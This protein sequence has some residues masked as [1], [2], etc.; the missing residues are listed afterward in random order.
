MNENLKWGVTV[1]VVVASSIGGLSYG[2][3]L[4]AIHQAK[5]KVS[6]QLIDPSSAQFRGLQYKGGNVCGEINGKNKL[7][8]YVGFQRFVVDSVGS[9]LID[10]EVDSISRP[11]WNL[12]WKGCY[13]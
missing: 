13:P 1:A 5:E 2:P 3:K 7:G 11:L 12:Q 8:A 4:V 10:S 9:A 6:R